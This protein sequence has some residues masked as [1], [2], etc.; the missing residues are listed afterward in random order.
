VVL[1]QRERSE[2]EQIESALKNFCRR[3]RC[4]CFYRSSIEV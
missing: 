3:V 2:N 4:H 1:V